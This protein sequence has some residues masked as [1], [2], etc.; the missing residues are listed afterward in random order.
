MSRFLNVAFDP[1]ADSQIFEVAYLTTRNRPNYQRLLLWYSKTRK[2]NGISMVTTITYA[3]W[4]GLSSKGQSM[5]N[6]YRVDKGLKPYEL[7]GSKWAKTKH[8]VNDTTI[9]SYFKNS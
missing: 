4:T 7:D 8:R 3:I 6:V 5:V 1:E 9:K 2:F